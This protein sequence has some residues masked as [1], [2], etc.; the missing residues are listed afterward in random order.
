MAVFYIGHDGTRAVDSAETQR[1]I[2]A[3]KALIC[4]LVTPESREAVSWP[5]LD[6]PAEPRTLFQFILGDRRLRIDQNRL[7]ADRP[8]F[9]VVTE[10]AGRAVRMEMYEGHDFLE[11]TYDLR[12]PELVGLALPKYME[13]DPNAYDP[14][15]FLH[16]MFGVP[17]EWTREMQRATHDPAMPGLA[18]QEPGEYRSSRIPT[19]ADREH[20]ENRLEDDRQ[21]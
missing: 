9:A 21:E 8:P 18:C 10:H 11:C 1:Q 19:D 16:E 6:D 4:A 15:K 13:S 14:A 17:K 2:D 12:A 7:M 20:W 5:D 3:V